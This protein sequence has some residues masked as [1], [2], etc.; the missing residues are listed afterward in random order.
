[1]IFRNFEDLNKTWRIIRDEVASGHLGAT[2]ANCNT[3]MYDP[4]R[5]GAGPKTTGRITV[6][7]KEDDYIDVGMKLIKLEAVHHDIKY[8]TLQATRSGMFAHVTSSAGFRISSVTIYWNSGD[9]YYGKQRPDTALHRYPCRNK[10]HYDPKSDKWKIH[11]V[12]GTSKEPDY[13][14]WVLV[15]NYDI[16]SD[17]NVT[18][19]WH[20]LKAKIEEG[21]I[22]AIRMECPTPRPPKAPPEIHVYTGA[23]PF[24]AI[25]NS[26]IRM[27]QHDI[28]YIKGGGTFPGD[29]KTLCWNNGRPGYKDER[30]ARPE[31]MENWR[32]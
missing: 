5:V 31:I 12:T 30:S 25:G 11:I 15:S 18:K 6:Y 9:P 14:K 8:K 7:A 29:T 24:H 4:V 23:S 16:N 1:M 28:D 13:G 20:R 3:I 17:I 10:Y 22:P 2:G 32:K 19:M 27:V 26:I 21:E